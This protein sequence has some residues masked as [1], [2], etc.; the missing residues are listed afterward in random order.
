MSKIYIKYGAMSASKTA[1]L[2]MTAHQYEENGKKPLI[3][4]PSF[5]TRSGSGKIE[6][7][8]GLSKPCI[9]FTK[10]DDLFHLIYTYNKQVDVILIDEFH[11]A[12]VHHIEELVE[13]SEEFNIP[14][15][16]YGLK[17]S[18]N[19]KIF[20]SFATALFWAEDIQ[21]IKSICC[22]CGQRKANNHLRYIDGKLDNDNEKLVG[23]I[24]NSIVIYKSVCKHCYYEAM[25]E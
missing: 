9:D 13:V 8:I 25:C 15:I 11:L 14:I 23:D 3:L 24:S 16:L 7:R 18:S 21:E 10:D 4:K 22:I 1:N 19:G 17:T 2:I 12:E 6:S 5:D 20:E